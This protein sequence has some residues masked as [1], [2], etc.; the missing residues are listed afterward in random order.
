MLKALP[1]LH[2]PRLKLRPFKLS[3]APVVAHLANDFSIAMNT[4]NLP[5]PYQEHMAYNWIKQHQLM[6]LSNEMVNLAI[7]LDSGN[8][9]IGTIGLELNMAAN[10]GE[11]GY[12]I[13]RPYWGHAYAPEA[14]QC[15]LH[16]GFTELKLQRIYALYKKGNQASKR[17][18]EKIGMSY[19]ATL[20][21]HIYK[22]GHYYDAIIYSLLKRDYKMSENQPTYLGG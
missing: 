5:F 6:Y 12:W 16:Y 3:D 7:T 2:G 9:V 20:C 11:L 22:W 15:V 10:H 18:L 14:S 19:E 8:K 17:V 1:Q 21:D 13:G 4:Q